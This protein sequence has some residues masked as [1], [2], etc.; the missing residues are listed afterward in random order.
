MFN[1]SS[2]I[3]PCDHGAAAVDIEIAKADVAWR[4]DRAAESGQILGVEPAAILPLMT[5][6]AL[7]MS[8]R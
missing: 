2:T 3:G 5:Q 1:A 7:A 4:F 6:I 8:P